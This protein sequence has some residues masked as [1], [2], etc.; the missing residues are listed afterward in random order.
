MPDTYLKH[1]EK[2]QESFENGLK[3]KGLT[4]IMQPRKGSKR[5]A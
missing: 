3:L 5:G 2:I 4:V 1:I